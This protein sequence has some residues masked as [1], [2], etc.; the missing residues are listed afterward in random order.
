MVAGPARGAIL[1]AC[2]RPWCDKRR[3]RS[4]S[5]LFLGRP[6][7]HPGTS[8][9]GARAATRHPGNKRQVLLL[10]CL[11]ACPRGG[12]PTALR[13][14]CVVTRLSHACAATQPRRLVCTHSLAIVIRCR[15]IV[16]PPTLCAPSR[17]HYVVS[18]LSRVNAVH[19]SLFIPAH[20]LWMSLASALSPARVHTLLPAARLL[21]MPAVSRLAR[22]LAAALRT[23]HRARIHVPYAAHCTA[24]LVPYLYHGVDEIDA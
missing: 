9:V 19:T 16:S 17:V 4:R 22:P 18:V 2:F 8:A 6:V 3:P 12:A 24:R 23:R 11:R 14:A 10:A 20:I 7:R 5:R 1:G 21:H 13:P 15:R